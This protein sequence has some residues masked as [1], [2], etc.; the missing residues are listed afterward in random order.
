MKRVI[1]IA[2]SILILASL[3]LAV[4]AEEMKSAKEPAAMKAMAPL[5]CGE[6]IGDLKTM[7]LIDLK[8]SKDPIIID[9][10]VT[11][12]CQSAGC[13]I[14]IKDGDKDLFV[15]AQGEKFFMPKNA[16]GASVRAMGVVKELDMPEEMLKHFAKEGMNLGEI[17]GPRKMMMMVASGVEL[18]PKSGQVF[19]VL[20]TKCPD[21]EAKVEKTEDC[22][23]GKHEM[24]ADCKGDCKDKKAEC[25]DDCK[26]KKA[27]CKGDCKDKKA[28]CKDDCKDKKADCKDDCKD[29]KADCKGD[30]KDKKTD[31]KG[32]C[33]DD[34][35]KDHK[36][37]K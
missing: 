17:K 36:E 18:T 16:A 35:K 30:C 20:N 9:G 34:G 26:D 37:V 22:K 31:C 10:I 27:D 25:K 32:D 3:V 1:S 14:I 7:K 21:E 19:A 23:D 28:D 8:P 33:K 5:S 13:W 11:T 29:K 24:K 6:K 4:N 2:I 12:V 15:K